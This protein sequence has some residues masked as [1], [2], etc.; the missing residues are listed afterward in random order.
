M[1]AATV[2]KNGVWQYGNAMSGTLAQRPASGRAPLG[3]FYFATDVSTNGALYVQTV[4][5]WVQI[6]TS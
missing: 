4:T 2:P 1:A 3:S 5:G 6:W